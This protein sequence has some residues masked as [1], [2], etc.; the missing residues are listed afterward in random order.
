MRE[1]GAAILKRL[2]LGGKRMS[3]LLEAAALTSARTFVDRAFLV[4]MR[5]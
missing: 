4:V 2:S 5:R 3:E 1:T